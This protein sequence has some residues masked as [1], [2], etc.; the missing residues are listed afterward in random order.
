MSSDAGS[1]P[2]ASN[3]IENKLFKQIKKSFILIIIFSLLPYA[4]SSAQDIPYARL[5]TKEHSSFSRV[6]IELS[7]LLPFSV[8]KRASLLLVEIKTNASLRIRR[9]P[10]ESPFVDSF[11]WTRGN[12]SLTLTIKAKHAN[13]KYDYFTTDNPPQ[14]IIDL[15][16]KVKNPKAIRTIVIDPGHGGLESGTKGKFGT[17]EKTVTLPISLRL[18]DFIERNLAFR[19]VMTREKD[20]SVTLDN[21]VA[22]ANNNEA[23]LFISIHANGSR[24]KNARGSETFF[25]SLNATDEEARR[26]AYM[27]NS[28]DELDERIEKE[29]EDEIKMILWDMAQAAYLQQSSQLA[30]FIQKELNLLLGTANRGIKQAPFKVL[31]GVACPAVLV[32]IAFLSNPVEEKKLL[33]EGFQS[34]VARAIYQGLVNFIRLYSQE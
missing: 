1:I 6:I 9:G 20:V 17:L 16:Q 4:F 18:K 14:L 29:K 27:E 7:S 5:S 33:D 26:L 11:S 28:A 2:A 25:L 24:R 8:E 23:D 30:E 32:E 19:V 34:K 3:I 21:R 12:D 10:S 13:F 31:S 22:K 15:S